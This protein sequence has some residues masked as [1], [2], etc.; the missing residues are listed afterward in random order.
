MPEPRAEE[1]EHVMVVGQGFV[2]GRWTAECSC[3]WESA[4]DHRYEAVAIDDW[5]N[6]CDVV[7]MEATGG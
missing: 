4:H 3:G 5:E 1:V 7:F 6:H 2:S